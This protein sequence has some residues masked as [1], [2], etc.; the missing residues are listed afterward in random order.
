MSHSF[1]PLTFRQALSKFATGVAVITTNSARGPVGI[2]VNSFAS[3]SLDP[4]LVLW[5]LA[6]SASRM[7]VFEHPENLAIHILSEDQAE[8]CK[9]FTKDGTAFPNGIDFNDA[10]TPLIDGCLARLECRRHATFDG[11][12][13]LIFVEHVEKVTTNSG[14][15]LLFFDSAFQALR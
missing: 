1:D 3:V 14:A 6:T 13:H 10:G 4:P 7:A 5:S 8:L 11:G 9:G 12:D 15:P 2:T